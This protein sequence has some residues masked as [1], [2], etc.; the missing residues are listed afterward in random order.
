MSPVPLS[1]LLVQVQPTSRR[2]GF[3]SAPNTSWADIGALDDLRDELDLAIAQPISNP[4]AFEQIG[5]TVPVR[6]HWEKFFMFLG[7]D[8]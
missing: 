2:E 5:I 8:G 6:E 4:E 3:A 7:M 1:P